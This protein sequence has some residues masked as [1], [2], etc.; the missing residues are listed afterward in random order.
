MNQTVDDLVNRGPLEPIELPARSYSA[1][2]RTLPYVMLRKLIR[3]VLKLNLAPD[4]P[5]E[6]IARI[7]KAIAGIQDKAINKA[8]HIDWLYLMAFIET[9]LDRTTL[10]LWKFHV[11]DVEPTMV[12]MVK[13]LRKRLL[14]LADEEERKN[15]A[16]R[17]TVS[18]HARQTPPVAAALPTAVQATTATET[19]PTR[20]MPARLSKRPAI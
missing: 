8:C 18:K 2:R 16:A 7:I 11:I 14:M 10:M 3:P 1:N 20:T 9:A 6:R 12:C 17:R 5:S 15:R 13:F 19:K 4:G